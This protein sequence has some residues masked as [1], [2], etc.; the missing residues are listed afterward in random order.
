[1]SHFLEVHPVCIGI[2]QIFRSNM[3]V[4]PEE[5]LATVKEIDRSQN[6]KVV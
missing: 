3:T 5:A 1:M 4:G 6:R 2:D